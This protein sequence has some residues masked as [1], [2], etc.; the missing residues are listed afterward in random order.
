MSQSAFLAAVRSVVMGV[1]SGA[2]GQAQGH[3]QLSEIVER[4][5][6]Q[7]WEIG[8]RRGGIEP[9]EMTGREQSERLNFIQTQQ[10]FVG[11]FVRDIHDSRAVTG[12]TVDRFL[13]RVDIWAQRYHHA[14]ELAHQMAASDRKAVW[15]YGDT[16]DHCGDC[17][18]VEGRV[19]RR[20]IWQKYGWFPGSA[21]LECGGW[22]C[23]C[24]LE[25]TTEP[26]MPGHPPYVR[27]RR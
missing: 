13:A 20:S 27:G 11:R 23:D 21:A 4:Y 10:A 1:W 25:D 12:G 24:R 16:I 6:S 22:R 15:V 26:A 3:A 2:L 7:A 8:A 18:R 14:V 5:L 17:S 9:G 19:H